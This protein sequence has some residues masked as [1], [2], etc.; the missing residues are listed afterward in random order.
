MP[1]ALPEPDGNTEEGTPLWRCPHCERLKPLEEFGWRRRDDIYP[2]LGM[3]H[4]QSWC[5]E[6]RAAG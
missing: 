1:V 5:M 6:C 3:Y 4:K 2:G